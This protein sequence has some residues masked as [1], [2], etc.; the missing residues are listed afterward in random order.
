M[1]IMEE[2]IGRIT[3]SQGK[4]FK[5]IEGNINTPN[6]SKKRKIVESSDGSESE[7]SNEEE[8]LNSEA[9]YSLHSDDEDSINSDLNDDKIEKCQRHITKNILKKLY[10]DISSKK[11]LNINLY[12]N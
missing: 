9:E 11:N 8:I 5:N 3:R 2:V 1:G 4:K 6:Y 10:D 12:L 7:Q